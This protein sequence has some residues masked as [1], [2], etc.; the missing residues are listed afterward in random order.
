MSYDN[1]IDMARNEEKA[2]SASDLDTIAERLRS[3]ECEPTM[4]KPRT[5]LIPVARHGLLDGH[6]YAEIALDD[7][8]SYAQVKAL[9]KVIEIDGRVYG[10][11]GWSSDTH[12]AYYS[13][14]YVPMAGAVKSR[15]K[16]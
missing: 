8:G 11:T 9:P 5:D 15:R 12:K 10:R 14:R 16:R 6:W 3:I 13:T 1:E 4:A 2:D 7:P